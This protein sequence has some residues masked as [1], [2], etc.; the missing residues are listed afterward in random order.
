LDQN[1]LDRSYTNNQYF[2]YVQDSIRLQP[3]LTVNFGLRYESFGSPRHDQGYVALQENPEPG[4]DYDYTGIRV[5]GSRTYQPDRNDF[6]FRAGFSYA[7]S[8]RASTVLRAAYGM[9]YDR[10]FDNLTLNVRNNSLRIERINTDGTVPTTLFQ[11]NG[12]FTQ[13]GKAIDDICRNDDP[14]AMRCRAA[15]MPPFPSLLAIDEHLRTPVVHNWSAGMEHRLTDSWLVEIRNVGSIG[16]GLITTN[17]RNRLAGEDVDRLAAGQP[18]VLFRSNEGRSSYVGLEARARRRSRNSMLEAAYTY[19]HAIDLQSEPLLGDFFDPDQANFRESATREGIASFTH[20]LRP[21]LDRGSADFDQRHNF[22]L[23]GAWTLPAPFRR[24]LFE[25]MLN[26][27]DLSWM[28]GWRSGFPVDIVARR[29][30]GVLRNVR[31]AAN[32][33]AE[34][35]EPFGATGKRRLLEASAFAPIAKDGEAV[36]CGSSS[37]LQSALGRNAFTGPGFWNVD[38]SVS[39]TIQVREK[40]RIQLRADSFNALNHLNLSS[41]DGNLCSGVNSNSS[42][43]VAAF[44]RDGAASPFPG[45]IPLSETSRRIDL[46]LRFVF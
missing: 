24:G 8:S 37:N 9:F 44:G 20:E 1:A 26:G 4:R 11:P 7:P 23:A 17:V 43:G 38:L 22:V 28:A 36:G 41:P 3:K 12:T 30:D 46:M 39:K 29:V 25:K 13:P 15:G 10:L 2:A 19:A 18:E 5:G 45:A 32:P 42:F 35:D 33:D 16:R 6:A 31:P 34:I 14:K 21:E 27:W 40:L